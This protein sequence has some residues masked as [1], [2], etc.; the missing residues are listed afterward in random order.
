[1]HSDLGHS[2]QAYARF[3]LL[4]AA[5]QQIDFG[6]PMHCQRVK[7]L[8]GLTWLE[9]CWKLISRQTASSC[10]RQSRHW[11]S[12]S[13]YLYFC[14]ETWKLNNSLTKSMCCAGWMEASHGDNIGII[15]DGN[16]LWWIRTAILQT[17]AWIIQWWHYILLY[18]SHL[19]HLLL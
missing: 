19:S 4:C 12:F 8:K 1:M 14:W 11:V 10:V 7:H 18:H 13:F 17:S 9:S 2:S 16:C 15:L 3:W 6:Q 5:I